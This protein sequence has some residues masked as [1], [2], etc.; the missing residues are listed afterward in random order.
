MG[1]DNRTF[2]LGDGMAVR[3]P[4]AAAYAPQIP[5]EHRW[6]PVLAPQLPLAVP[7]PLALGQPGEGY[8][9]HWSINKWLPGEPLGAFGPLQAQ[10]LADFLKALQGLDV[11]GGPEAGADNFHRGGSLRVYDSQTRDAIALLGS[12]IDAA[13]AGCVWEAALATRHEGPPAWLH[14][15]IS[16]ANLLVDDGELAGVI[17]FGCCAVGD[18]SCDLAIAW[19]GMDRRGREA[20]RDALPLD[21]GCWARARGW[22]LWKSLL[23]CAGLSA[24]RPA[25]RTRGFAALEEVLNGDG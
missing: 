15:D 8:P 4:S 19:T 16:P 6:L 9:W 14:G 10:G 12:Q 23:E 13:A 22:A 24:A 21:E 17:D 3:L 7:V 1:W 18:P 20:F 25:A 5:K 2:R 11:S